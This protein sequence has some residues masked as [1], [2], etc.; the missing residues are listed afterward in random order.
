MIERLLSGEMDWLTCE[1]SG[2]LGQAPIGRAAILSGA[3]NPLHAGHEA[4]AAAAARVL[5]RS[6]V[7]ELPLINADKP[8]LDAAEIDRR[9]AQ[10]AGRHRVALTRSPLFRQK[11]QLFPESVFVVGYDTA[12]RLLEARYYGNASA[13]DA[14]LSELADR[15]CRF[16][17]A[18]RLHRGTLHTVADLQVDAR[19]QD[20]FIELP[21]SQ[22]RMDVSSTE[23][24]GGPR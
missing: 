10:F 13:R 6:L 21:A 12:E 19:F 2:S 15:G 24:R 3:F 17:V 4:L 16:L 7:F 11:A 20:T 9:L 22:F 5:D 1:P 8:P 23:L 18:A 14:A